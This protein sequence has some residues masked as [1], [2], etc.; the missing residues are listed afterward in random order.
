[1]IEYCKLNGLDDG[2]AYDRL[3]AWVDKI[4]EDDNAENKLNGS[5]CES[6]DSDILAVLKIKD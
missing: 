5:D 4:P 3:V 6:I 1:M 2:S